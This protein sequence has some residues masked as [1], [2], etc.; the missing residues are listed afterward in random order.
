MLHASKKTSPAVMLVLCVIAWRGVASTPA[1][2]RNYGP[3]VRSF[4]SFI[5]QEEE[6]LAFQIRNNEISRKEYVRSKNRLEIP[7]QT[8]LE[9]FRKTR[10]D[11]VPEFHV[12]VASEVD[13]LIPDGVAAM[14]T[15]SIG[16]T[17]AGK[18]RYVGRVLRGEAYYIVERISDN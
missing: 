11:H 14:K 18:W 6:E 10:E 8:V 1:Q 16:A 2:S 12:V 13:S 7:K 5:K 15:A 4:L 17:I 9:R 3:E